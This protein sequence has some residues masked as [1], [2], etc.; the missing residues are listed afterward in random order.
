MTAQ[1]AMP[2]TASPDQ[3]VP[4]VLL[5]HA[6]RGLTQE[7]ID[8]AATYAAHGYLALAVDLYNGKTTEDFS[9]AAALMAAMDATQCT[10][11]AVAWVNWLRAQKACTGRVGAIG[12]C[13]GGTWSLNT[14][15]ATPVDATVVYYGNVER[16]EDQVAALKGPV[17][18]HFG[19]QDAYFGEDNGKGMVKSFEAAMAKAGK[20]VKNYG[21]DAGHAFANPGGDYALTSSA[22]VADDRTWDFLEHH[23]S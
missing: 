5:F 21:Y 4:G 13:L 8:A 19:T 15:I 6:F 17:L 14:S 16:T 22:R 10:E 2:D 23:L 7:F 3:P 9:E 12:W 1:V 18:G 20:S 11:V